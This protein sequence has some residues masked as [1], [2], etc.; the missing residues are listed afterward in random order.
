[1]C[2]RDSTTTAASAV[3]RCV[4]KAV[5]RSE[6]RLASV[7]AQVTAQSTSVFS[8]GRHRISRQSERLTDRSRRRLENGSQ[9][10]DVLEARL[11]A[12]DPAQALKRG[13]SITTTTDGQLVRR[14]D[15]VGVGASITTRLAQGTV[16]STVDAIDPS[17]SSQ[18]TP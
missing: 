14:A 11:S 18:D 13:Y 3:H 8:N 15:Q 12:A 10:L 7:Q 9:L 1:M 5:H 16:T 4:D 6:Q 2:I 17:S